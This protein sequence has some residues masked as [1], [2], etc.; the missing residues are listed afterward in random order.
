MSTQLTGAFTPYTSE[1]SAEAKKAFTAAIK[2]ILGVTYSP[3]AVS[4]Q[5]VAGTNYKFFCNTEATTASPV[6]GA[7]IVNVYAPLDGDAH[8]T[9]IQAL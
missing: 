4:T 5:I 3:V 7:A 1:I 2:G 9:H 6:A 8:V